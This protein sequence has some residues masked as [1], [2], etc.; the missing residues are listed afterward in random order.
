MTTLRATKVQNNGT[1][2]TFPHFSRAIRDWLRQVTAVNELEQ[3]SDR[4][5]RDIGVEREDIERVARRE[6]ARLR[7]T[8]LITK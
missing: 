6:L 8:D 2:V 7:A 4:A 3:L 1:I 5:L